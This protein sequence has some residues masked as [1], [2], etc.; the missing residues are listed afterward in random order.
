MS[1]RL[2]WTGADNAGVSLLR[3]GEEAEDGQTMETGDVNDRALCIG[4]LV[5]EGNHATIRA[6]LAAAAA[7]NDAHPGVLAPDP[8]YDPTPDCPTCGQPPE[9][10]CPYGSCSGRP[11][12]EGATA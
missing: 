5:I 9:R 10:P 7:L 12:T 6:V 1:V 11:S 8:D 4:P 2:E 3:R